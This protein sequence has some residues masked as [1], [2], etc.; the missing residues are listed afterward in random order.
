MQNMKAMLIFFKSYSSLS[1]F[2]NQQ[3]EFYFG[4]VLYARK[5]YVYIP[6]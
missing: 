1:D 6:D 2:Y 5:M 4:I 3:H